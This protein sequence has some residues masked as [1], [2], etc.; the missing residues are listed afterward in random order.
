MVVIKWK[1][2]AVLNSRK[3]KAEIDQ[4]KTDPF[5]AIIWNNQEI[6]IATKPIFYESWH[7]VGVTEVKHLK[8]Q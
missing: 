5:S 4:E 6:K 2:V 1:R 8:P 3:T 7:K